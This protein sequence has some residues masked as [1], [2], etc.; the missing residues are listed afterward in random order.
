M[1]KRVGRLDRYKWS[2][3]FG[4]GSEHHDW[5]IVC[6]HGGVNFHATVNEKY[7]TTAGLEFHFCSPPDHMRNDPPSHID[8]PVTGGRCWHDGTSLY[9]TEQLW[10]MIEPLL[11]RG[12]HAAIFGIL[13]EE[14]RE[15]GLEADPPSE[16][17]QMTVPELLDKAVSP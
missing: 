7:G 4:L 9:A 15:H 13:H 2:N 1:D 6:R 5:R 17:R 10:P 11:N 3:P 8:C 14:A 16:G 12:D